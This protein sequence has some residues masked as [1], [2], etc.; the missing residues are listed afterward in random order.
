MG[1]GVGEGVGVPSV[2]VAVGACTTGVVPDPPDVDEDVPPL[3]IAATPPIQQTSSTAAAMP[4]QR[5]RRD[6]LG[7]IGGG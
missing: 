6:L 3:A 1:V 4:I 7:G 2:G 5:L